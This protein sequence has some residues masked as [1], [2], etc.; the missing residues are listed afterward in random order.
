[1]FYFRSPTIFSQ[2]RKIHHGLV[3]LAKT[4]FNT[5]QGNKTSLSICNKSAK[6]PRKTIKGLSNVWGTQ[7]DYLS[8]FI[9]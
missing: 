5:I 8:I 1:M 6:L 7:I 4:K 3:A 9:C 2:N